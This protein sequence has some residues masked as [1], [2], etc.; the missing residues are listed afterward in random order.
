MKKKLLVTFVVVFSLLFCLSI[1]SNAE[2]YGDYTYW[3]SNGQATITDCNTDINGDVVIPSTLGGY[4]VTSID[5]YAFSNCWLLDSIT[6]PN[7]ITSIGDSAFAHCTS[8]SKII[9]AN[10][11]KYVGSEAFKN[12]G[13]YNNQS[14]WEDGVLYVGKSVIAANSDIMPTK[15]TIKSGTI[16][17]GDGAF[18]K[19]KY[20][21]TLS[22][23]DSVE[24]I[25]DSAFAMCSSLS[26]ITIP[27]GV[28]EI[29]DWTFSQCTGIKKINLHDGITCIGLNSFNQC[30]NLDT[31]ELPNSILSIDEGAFAN[32][33]K[34]NNIT[35]PE[36]ITSIEGFCFQNCDSLSQI[37]IPN[38]VVKIGTFAFRDCD[39]LNKITLPSSVLSIEALAFDGCDNLETINYNGKSAL[40]DEIIID[41]DN[42]PFEKAHK[43]YFFYLDLYD[44]N[45]N[46]I[47][48]TMQNAEMKIDTSLISENYDYSLYYD[49]E[50]TIK[51]DL[52]VPLSNNLKLYAIVAPS[53]YSTFTVQNYSKF[54]F[55]TVDL[56]NLEEGCTVLLATYD[57]NGKMIEI[58]TDTYTGETIPFTVSGNYETIKIMVWSDLSKIVPLCKAN[59]TPTK[60]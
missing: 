48:R 38:K 7:N 47:S 14:N 50:M 56:F 36:N 9:G 2:T 51:Y 15:Y 54:D 29:S 46:L 6:I 27:N 11:L 24:Y 19:C 55:V 32:C 25:N 23:P 60:K 13:Y 3:V 49:K 39:A 41:S 59:T 58:Q 37:T 12:T 18:R 5:R 42:A 17:I 4:P 35:I 34:L 20:L 28:T 57:I 30:E 8:L 52:S 22:I 43:K 40:F 33:T 45:D 1:T 16:C 21:S 53:P 31:I 26:E 10:N 44:A